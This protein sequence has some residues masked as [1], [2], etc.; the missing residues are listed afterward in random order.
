MQK[1]LLC[2]GV[3]KVV[4]DIRMFTCR[5]CYSIAETSKCVMNSEMNSSLTN[6]KMIQNVICKLRAMFSSYRVVA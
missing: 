1:R 4:N 2:I 6:N 5:H 3:H